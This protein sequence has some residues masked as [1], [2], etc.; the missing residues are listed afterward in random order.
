[1]RA[2]NSH[3]LRARRDNRNRWKIDPDELTKWRSHSVRTQP[4]AHPDDS[5][6][7]KAAL[8]RETVRA[9]AAERAR[10]Q[11]EASRDQWRQMAETLA[12]RP[13]FRWPWHR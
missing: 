8:A 12:A 13:R 2:I 1:M 9:D 10:D 6:D 4:V 3:E 5:A 11:A 7:L